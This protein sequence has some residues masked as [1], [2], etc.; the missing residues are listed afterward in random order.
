M[1]SPPIYLHIYTYLH[2]FV[3]LIQSYFCEQRGIVGTLNWV[4]LWVIE[5]D[6]N[7]LSVTHQ[8]TQRY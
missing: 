6:I 3:W 1:E 4:I 7:S 8:H 2:M 5:Q